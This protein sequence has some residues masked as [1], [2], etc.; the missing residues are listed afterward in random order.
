MELYGFL[1]LDT[2]DWVDGLFSN[3]F[4]EIN[5]P[6]EKEERRYV[7]FDGD[8][9][10]LWIENMNSVMD[11]NKLLT[12]ANGER[13]RLENYCALLFEVGNLAFA[14]P[15]TVSRAGMVYVDPKNLGYEP[16]WNKWLSNR[17]ENEREFLT[18]LYEKFIPPAIAFITEGLDGSQQ[19]IPLK[20]VIHQTNLNLIT[21]FCQVFKAMFPLDDGQIYNPENIECGFV[22]CLYSSL[23]AT[24]LEDGRILFDDFIKKTLG[25]M[26]VE[27]TIENPATSNQCPTSRPTLYEYFFDQ[28]KLIWMAWEWLV[29]KYIHD[30]NVKFSEILVPTV[31]T[32]RIEWVLNLMNEIKRPVLL[33][34]ETGTS[35]TAI[36]SSYLRKLNPDVYIILNINFSSRTSSM[37]V[38]RIIET[39]VEKRTKDTYGPPIG[40]KLAAFIDDMNMPI[41]DEYGTQQPIALLK[42]LFENGGMYDRGKDLNWKKFKDIGFFAGMGCAGG[43]RNEVDPRFISMFSVYNLLFPQDGTLT[44]IYSSIL[45]GH[46]SIFTED[47]LPIADN[48]IKMTL[49][50]FKII[51]VELPPTPTKFHYIFNLKDLSRIYS[52]MLLTHPN[53]FKEPKQLVRVWRNEFTRVICDR[54]ISQEDISF[55][56]ESISK[57]IVNMYPRPPKLDL[58][59]PTLSVVENEEGEEEDRMDEDVPEVS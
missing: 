26:Q 6:I 59:M 41:V 58:S 12:L 29:P 20:T 10:A 31:D 39:A 30:R 17:P 16:Y 9:D 25:M 8:V 46:L 48:L 35:K 55:M 49:N 23:G 32:L 4:R 2:R 33:V 36:I 57:E 24:L 37:D 27:D 47:L 43:G 50:L 34:G 21:Q 7:C 19:G 28:T 14:S 44:H 11:D 45:K 1:D 52:G 5:R 38:Q 18:E 15:A 56:K 13:I 22:Q 51:I 40:K 3:I 53:F 54:L 42:H